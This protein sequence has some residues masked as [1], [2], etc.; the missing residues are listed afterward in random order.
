MIILILVATLHP[1]GL[2]VEL[3]SVPLTILLC[4]STYMHNVDAS[5]MTCLMFS[6]S[7]R[8]SKF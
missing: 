7:S 5:V 3:L 2:R 8:L 4:H 6:E 1:C